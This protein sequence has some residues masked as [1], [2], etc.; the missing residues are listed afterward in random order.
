MTSFRPNISLNF[1]QIIRNPSITVS[2]ANIQELGE[3][4]IAGISQHVRCYDPT[5][6][7]EAVHL[8]GYSNE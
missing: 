3:A 4:I 2:S 5:A 6:S 8:V 7:T 1:A